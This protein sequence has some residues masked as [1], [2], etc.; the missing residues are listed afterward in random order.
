MEIPSEVGWAV[1]E[2]GASGG[3]PTSQ[4]DFGAL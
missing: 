4:F 3:R 1:R 2:A